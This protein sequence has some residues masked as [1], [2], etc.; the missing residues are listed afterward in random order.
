VN[1]LPF[2]WA[3]LRRKT[4]LSI[5][6]LALLVIA[7]AVV[8]AVEGLTSAV[9]HAIAS[10]RPDRL[11]VS[12]KI[13]PRVPLPIAQGDWLKRLA[14]VRRFAPRYQ[15]AAAYQRP[16]QAVAICATDIDALFAIYPEHAVDPSQLRA[17]HR[18]R[19]GAIVGRGV[20]RHYGWTIGQRITLQSPLTRQDGTGNW[21]LEIVGIWSGASDDVEDD[22]LMIFTNYDYIN[23]SLPIG[24]ARDTMQFAVL[25]IAAAARAEA[26]ERTI[27][28][29]YANSSHGT[30]TQSEHQIEQF[31]VAPFADIDTVGHRIVGATLFVLLFATSALMMKSIRERTPELEI[32]KAGGHSATHVLLLIL[33]ESLVLCVVGAAIGLFVGTRLL[34]LARSQVALVTVPHGIDWIGFAYATVLAF[35]A[36]GMAAWRGR[37]VPI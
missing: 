27:D 23:G 19:D 37:K 5:L 1:S 35:A 25:Q 36:A 16:Q 11:Y 18:H 21:S 33:V 3:G 17:M 2:I 30:L 28:S 20:M 8:G 32:L 10:A 13:N 14:G 7:F 34:L 22:S 26:I 29:H 15:F 9:N 6:I 12:S 4:G 31:L 24:P